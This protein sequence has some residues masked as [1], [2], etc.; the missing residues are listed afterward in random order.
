MSRQAVGVPFQLQGPDLHL[1][2]PDLLQLLQLPLAVQGHPPQLLLQ[3]LLQRLHGLRDGDAVDVDQGVDDLVRLVLGA[4]GG[5]GGGGAHGG[6]PVQGVARGALPGG[7]QLVPDPRRLR[8]LHALGL[9]QVGQRLL[10][11]LLLLLRGVLLQKLLVQQLLL[12]L[13]LLQLLLVLQL[14]LLVLQLLLVYLLLVLQLLLLL[15]LLPVLLLLLLQLRLGARVDLGHLQ[16]I[17]VQRN[18]GQ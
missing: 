18:L 1:Q 2:G 7:P 17:V 6:R 3:A 12:L 15:Q 8:P 9:H 10:A 5:G 13:V 4:R 11:L 16:V 14:L